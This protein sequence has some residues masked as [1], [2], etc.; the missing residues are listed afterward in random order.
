[1]KISLRKSPKLNDPPMSFHN[2]RPYPW[3]LKEWDAYYEESDS[4]KEDPT[5]TL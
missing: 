3:K 4:N 2:G 1:M 5:T